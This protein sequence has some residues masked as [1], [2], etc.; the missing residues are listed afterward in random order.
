M[1]YLA[2]HFVEHK[3]AARGEDVWVILFCGNL[4]LHLDESVKN[5]LGKIKVFLCFLPPKM[6]NFFQPIDAGLG[7]LVKLSVGRHLDEWLMNNYNMFRWVVTK[8]TSEICILTTIILGKPMSG[9]VD[10]YIEGVCFA[11]Y[12]HTGLLFTVTAKETQNSKIIPQGIE[13]LTFRIP[14]EPI[15]SLNL[16]EELE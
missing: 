6:K 7:R 3:F 11:C 16:V 14:T 13:K 1:R 12:E 5:I 4:S 9:F 10:N 15:I 2:R 8:T